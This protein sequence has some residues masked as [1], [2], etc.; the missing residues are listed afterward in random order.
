[1]D[2]IKKK[3]NDLFEDFENFQKIILF[4][5]F[6]NMNS[7]ASK[8][9]NLK[10]W[11]FE[12][13][14]NIFFKIEKNLNILLFFFKIEKIQKISKSKKIWKSENFEILRFLRFSRFQD[15]WWF[16]AD[17]QDFDAFQYFSIFGRFFPLCTECM[18]RK[19]FFKLCNVNFKW[20]LNKFIS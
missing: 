8:I 3:K 10:I 18:H 13:F 15:C 9:W 4:S 11:D 1:M 6:V 12:H 16:F 14:E 20:T 7:V 5:R 17:S 19:S 2:F